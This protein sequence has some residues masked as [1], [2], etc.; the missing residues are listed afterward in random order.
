MKRKLSKILL[1]LLSMCSL[2]C[3][4]AQPTLVVQ[5]GI[6]TLNDAIAANKG[7]VIYQLKAGE[8][9][10]ITSIIQ[11]SDFDL[12]IIGAEPATPGGMPAT[13]QTGND[14]AGAVFGQMFNSLANLT[15]KNIYFVNCDLSGTIGGQFMTN[16]ATNARTI[17]TKCIFNPTSFGN[18]FVLSGSNSKNYFTDNLVMNMGHELNPNDG[19]LFV[20]DNDTGVGFDTLLVQNNTFVAMGT[21]MHSGNFN[22]HIVNFS[23]WDHN[24]V[25]LQKSQIDWQNLERE[26]YW[27]NNLMFDVQTQP[28][29]VTWQPMPGADSKKPVPSLIYADT[30]ANDVFPSATTQFVQYNLHYRNP[31]FYTQLVTLNQIAKTNAKPHMYYVP[32]AWP[33]D[34]AKV[35]RETEMFAN[36]TSFPKWK[37]GHTLIDIDP[38]FV[39]PMIYKRSDSLVQWTNPATQIH[40]MGLPSGNYPAASTWPKWHWYPSNGSMDLSINSDWPAFNGRY[41]N[42]AL[43][44]A[45]IEGLPL[46]DLNWFPAQKAFWL[47]H[48]AEID[49]HMRGANDAKMTFTGLKDIHTD[50]FSFYPNPTKDMIALKG[51]RNAD[52]AICTLDGRVVKT[53]QNVTILNVSDLRPGYYLITIKEGNLSSTEKL[54]IQK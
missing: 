27:T 52:V 13:L 19:H 17:I 26:Y 46:G 49:N 16:A 42:P 25:I 20:T 7:N 28:W 41:T 35:S 47:A 30:V 34:S 29:A 40:A 39:D 44:T 15:L 48:K 33:V 14:A 6:G 12:T 11:N 23:K 54:M 3:F 53:A 2:N 10:Q 43:L 21:T 5:P 9:Y 8:W 1:A 4:A 37:N 31:K 18:G 51:V 22:K 38:Q 32:I 50:R 36:R 45:S 24:S